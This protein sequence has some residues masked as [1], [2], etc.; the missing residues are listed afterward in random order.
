MT[1]A[2]FIETF[3]PQ[4]ALLASSIIVVLGWYV[5][6]RLSSHRDLMNKR[7]ELSITYLIEAYR[8]LEHCGN[9]KVVTKEIV[10]EM[11]KTL[12]DIQLFGF[13]RH[14]ELLLE[15]RSEYEQKKSASLEP[16]LNEL[17]KDLREKLNL[18]S[19][20]KNRITIRFNQPTTNPT[21][22]SNVL[23]TTESK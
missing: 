3:T 18:E 1:V 5:V 11:E 9:R 13:K 23:P 8:R 21:T 2:L 22:T 14:V 20:P 7:R 19:L 15:F 6:H 16:L 10:S 17:R 4:L 12:T